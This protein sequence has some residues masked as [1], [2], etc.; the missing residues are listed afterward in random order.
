MRVL[1]NNGSGTLANVANGITL[2]GRQRRQGDQPEPGRPAAR[3]TLQ[4]AVD[5]AW[6][7]GVFLA[8]AAGNSNTSST[9]NAYPGAYAN[10]FA[11]ASTTST[12]ARSSFSNYGSW[13]E[14]AAPGSR[15]TRPG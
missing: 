1:D 14:V 10:C 3:A 15:S 5:Y 6:S 4:N 8:C 13:V 2:G 12:D 7:K 11:V 9:A